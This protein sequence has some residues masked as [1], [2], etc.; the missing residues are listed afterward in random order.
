MQYSIDTCLGILT[1]LSTTYRVATIFVLATGSILLYPVFY[2]FIAG[3]K[4]NKENITSSIGNTAKYIYLNRIHK[5]KTISKET[6]DKEFNIF[7]NKRYG[8]R[9][10]I[11]PMALLTIITIIIGSLMA[12]FILN[13]DDY[14]WKPNVNLNPTAAAALA[15]AYMWVTNEFISRA[16]RLDFSPSDIQSASLRLIISVAVGLAFGSVVKNEV[17]AFVAFGLGAFP[18]T[19]IQIALR[20]LS[21]KQLGLELGAT[22]TN[23]LLHLD[24]VDQSLVERLSNDDITS[25]A[26]LAYCD[27]IQLTMSS[28]LS[29][30]DIF[31]LV[32]QALAW[33]Y[34]GDKLSVIR[35]MGIRGA[36]EARALVDFLA[37]VEKD[38]SEKL[39]KEQFWPTK[40]IL[41]RLS[42][43][44][45][46]DIQSTKL[47]LGQI[48]FD[49][50]T[51]FLYS[52]WEES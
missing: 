28:N 6:A 36:Y 9:R 19:T 4:R 7:Y 18:L 12:E 33:I 8:R 38:D 26:Q 51:V 34:V 45:E 39:I 27:P 10:F 20:Q 3:W 22:A 23:Q 48:A 44:L 32:S 29:L 14:V 49:P 41:A 47:L 25:V 24:G 1:F 37:A 42:E 2:Y 5:L 16:R 13:I 21:N 50:Y 43:K 17:A 31:D 11:I 46:L 15:G 40:D 52:T 35:L 30:N